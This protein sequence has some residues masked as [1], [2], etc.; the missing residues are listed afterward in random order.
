LP[1][2]AAIRPHFPAQAISEVIGLKTSQSS[3]LPADDTGEA[4]WCFSQEPFR[5][6][7]NALCR[8]MTMHVAAGTMS[9][10]DSS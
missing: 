3:A 8:G 9:S 4:R 1:A 5:L 2:L 6:S 7:S 10:A